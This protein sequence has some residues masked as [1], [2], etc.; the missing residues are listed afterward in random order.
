MADDVLVAKLLNYICGSGGYVELTALLKPLSPLGSRKT[1][2]EA[3]EWLKT[4]GPEVGFVCVK[5]HDDKIIGVRIDLRKKICHQYA[6]KGSCRRGQGKCKYWHICKSYIEG[7]CDGKCGLSH[8][9]HSEENKRKVRELGLEKHSN[10]TVRNNV[11]WSLPQVCQLY[12]R[13]ECKSDKCPYLHVCSRVA[14]GSS[15]KCALS[16]SLSDSHNIKILK[17]YDLV[18]PHGVINVDFV[19]CS[20]LVLID[21][22][23]IETRKSPGGTVVTKETRSAILNGKQDGSSLGKTQTPAVSTK[24]LSRK[25]Q[26][27]TSSSVASSVE[28]QVNNCLKAKVLFECL[29]KEFNCSAPFTVL[30]NRKYVNE[31]QDASLFLKENSDKFLFTRNENGDIKD[32]IAFCPKL[33]LCF[34]FVLVNE[35]KKEHCPSFHLCR[36]FI[37]GSCSRGEKCSRSHKFRNK[38]DQQT[39]MKLDLDWLTNE[40]LRQLMLSSSPQVC[41]NYNKGKCTNIS[42]CPRVHICKDFVVNACK[43]G[44]ACRFQH[45]GAFDSHETKSLLEKYGLGKISHNSVLKTILVCKEDSDPQIPRPASVSSL[46]TKDEDVAT[47]R[48]MPSSQRR[49]VAQEQ[50]PSASSSSSSVPAY[51]KLA[52]SKKAVLACISKEYNGSV[53]FAVVSKRQDLFPEHSENIAAWFRNRKESFRLVER[54]DGTI[55]EVK[56]FCRRAGFCFNYTSVTSCSREDCHYFHVCREYVAGSCRFG[57]R[58]KWNHSFQFDQDRKFI[59]KLDLDDLTDE[60]LC[61]V[62]KLSMPQVCLDYNDGEC[63]HGE[64]CPLVHV[65]RDF[66][67]KRCHDT[68]DC[69]LEH[70]EALLTPHTSGI[71]QNYGLKC[72]DGNLNFVLNALLVCEKT[73]SNVPKPTTS[74]SKI[75]AAAQDSTKQFSQCQTKPSDPWNKTNSS[76]SS[77]VNVRTPCLPTEQKVFECLC[78]GFGSSDFSEIAERKDLFPHGLESAERWFRKTKGS[79]LLTEN[80]RGMILQVDAFSARARLCLN[81]NNNGKCDKHDCTYLH[82]CRDF[83]TDSCNSGVTC[84]LNHHFHNQRDKALLSRIKLDQFTDLQLQRLVLSSTPQICVDYNNNI[85]SRGDSCTKIHMCCGYLRKCCSGEYECGLDHETAMNTDQTQ[86]VLR[87]LMLDNVGKHDVLGMILDDK[88]SLSGKDKTKCEYRIFKPRMT[89]VHQGTLFRLVWVS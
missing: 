48:N 12:L 58:C 29:C 86:A 19:R 37:T 67:K 30:E 72:T 57:A 45:T 10:G 68:N 40:Q 55:L 70:E 41:I 7:I 50:Q 18:P 49:R 54:A 83:V 32:I 16:H 76:V 38:R 56:A 31:L 81:Y 24:P 82:I 22:K 53:P 89:L 51:E 11:A 63:Q 35:C 88:L 75:T 65:C 4:Q 79:F 80:D 84:P 14:Q 20:I 6:V 5:D 42:T 85:C 28:K 60:E 77:S 13:N 62:I 64:S 26:P 47:S 73:D 36:K 61:K 1:K 71:L 3:K 8:N 69:G 27:A 9:F 23:C 39:V 34:D 52:P 21:Q 59:S 43:T 15:C 74:K 33:R 66:L 78:R 2:P 17:Q 25:D 87:R 46:P 44:D